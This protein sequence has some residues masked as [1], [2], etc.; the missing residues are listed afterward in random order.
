MQFED[1]MITKIF[2]FQFVNSYASFFYLA[3]VAK[4]MGECALC[5]V[6][7]FIYF[8]YVHLLLLFEKGCAEIYNDLCCLFLLLKH[9]TFI[10]QNNCLTSH[11]NQL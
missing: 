11:D 3:F 6:V 10:F 7:R 4:T 9:F 2:L 8:V 1:S 5:M